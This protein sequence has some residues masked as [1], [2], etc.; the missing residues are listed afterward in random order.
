MQEWASKGQIALTV[1]ENALVYNPCTKQVETKGGIHCREAAM[2]W[3]F[4]GCAIPDDLAEQ[5]ALGQIDTNNIACEL[6]DVNV[7][8][9][10]AMEGWLTEDMIEGATLLP[11]PWPATFQPTIQVVSAWCY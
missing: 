4:L 2:R 3:P 10:V 9:P 8:A 1:F 11:L 6:P 5:R 7:A